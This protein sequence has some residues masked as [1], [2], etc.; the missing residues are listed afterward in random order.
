M[1][2]PPHVA[3]L[4]GSLRDGSYTRV[5]VRHALEAAGDRGASTDLVDLRD[6]DLPVYD[7]DHDDAGDAGALRERV[8]AA[9][10]IVLGT[11]M[12]HGS[13]ASPLKVALDYCGFD[14]F[15]GKTVGLL[16]VSGGGFPLPALEH[17]RSVCRS[18]DAWVV[19]YQA[20]VPNVRSRVE[21]GAVVDPDAAE[22]LA[23]LGDRVVRYAR[24]EPDPTTFESDQNV[25]A[26]D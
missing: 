16:A 12:Y 18:L 21:D 14:E 20:A 5:A 17:L 24:I 8:R 15:R 23:T 9:D 25:G 2:E 3:G 10:S 11:P 19:P 13:Y 26:D 1:V 22:R 4:V 7:A 6:L